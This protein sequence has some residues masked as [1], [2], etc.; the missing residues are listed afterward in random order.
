M[1]EQKRAEMRGDLLALLLLL[2]VVS[3]QPDHDSDVRAWIRL[4]R[5]MSHLLS[6]SPAE[7]K[8]EDGD[9]SQEQEDYQVL[10]TFEVYEERRYPSAN[11]AC[12]EMTYD[13]PQET[14]PWGVWGV[15]SAFISDN[16]S[17]SEPRPQ[18]TM[19]KRLYKYIGGENRQGQKMEMTRP[20]W[21][22]LVV[23]EEEGQITSTM[24]STSVRSSSQTPRNLWSR[25]C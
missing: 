21:T 18:S 24:F 15:I 19:F 4:K 9:H 8:V 6:L 20:V 2:L 12:T 1:G 5:V 14:E 10:Q 16:L 3:G 25:R 7:E 22:K 23:S 17:P 11:Y 13:I